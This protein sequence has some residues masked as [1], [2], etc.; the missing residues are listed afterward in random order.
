MTFC[1]GSESPL[2]V[3][4]VHRW[5]M[6]ESARWRAALSSQAAIRSCPSVPGMRYPNWSWRS[7]YLKADGPSNS[8]GRRLLAAGGE[9]E[10]DQQ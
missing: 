7:R 3:T 10:G 2:A 1:S 8:A 4:W 9:H 6:T 5:T